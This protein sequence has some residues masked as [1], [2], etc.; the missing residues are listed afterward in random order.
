[1][2]IKLGEDPRPHSRALG[3]SSL[4]LR[5]R[6][7]SDIDSL[8]NLGVDP[9]HTGRKPAVILIPAI[10]LPNLALRAAMPIN[11]LRV[12]TIRLPLAGGQARNVFQDVQIVFVELIRVGMLAALVLAV[13]LQE[14]NVASFQLLNAVD[15]VLGNGFHWWVDSL[16]ES[17]PIKTRSGRHHRRRLGPRWWKARYERRSGHSSPSARGCRPWRCDLIIRRVCGIG[18]GSRPSQMQ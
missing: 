16:A 9:M 7:S 14:M 3:D 13:S 15:F 11:T 18:I 12:I 8:D 10:L 6:T 17:I 2:K 4:P 1:M 5:I